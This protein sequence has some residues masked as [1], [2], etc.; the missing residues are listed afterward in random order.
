MGKK[1]AGKSFGDGVK[2]KFLV[3]T[4]KN[5]N[6]NEEEKKQAKMEA[7]ELLEGFIHAM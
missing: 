2:E 5:K 3:I 7:I 1:E 6:G 4:D